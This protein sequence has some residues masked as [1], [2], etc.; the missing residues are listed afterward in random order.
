LYPHPYTGWGKALVAGHFDHWW[1]NHFG[2]LFVINQWVSIKTD[3]E[4]VIVAAV[5][6]LNAFVI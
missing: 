4:A 1:C 5:V 2:W 3:A 6:A